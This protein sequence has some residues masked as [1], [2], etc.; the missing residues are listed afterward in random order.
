MA[1]QQQTSS[2]PVVRTV[3]ALRTA[4]LNARRQGQRIGFVPTMGALHDGHLSLCKAAGQHAPFVVVS[5]FVNPTQF[6]PNEDFAKYP[7]TEAADIAKL[8]A[9]R[10]AHLIYAPYPQ[11]VYPAG[12]ATSIVPLG[13]AEGLES[14]FRPQF[15]TGV[16]TVV[17]KLFTQVQPDF[18]VFGEKDYQQ[19]MVIRQLARDIDLPVRVIG[20][21]TIREED[22]LALS[23]RNAY[24][25]ANARKIAG[26]LNVIMREASM[27]IVGGHDIAEV[28]ARGKNLLTEAGFDAVDYLE[29]REAETLRPV[30]DRARPLRILAAVRIGGTRLIDNMAVA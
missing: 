24:L 21:P 6:A 4:V 8:A 11:E 19:L 25:D 26:R 22:G 2:I 23:S 3:S 9:A 30:S 1:Q 10:A 28:T 17:A 15:F 13:V 27:A 16:A 14:E 29:V 7:R 18:A 20:A 5:I 12:F